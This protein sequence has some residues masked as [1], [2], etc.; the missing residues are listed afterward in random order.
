MRGAL[1]VIAVVVMLTGCGSPSV[2]S[3]GRSEVYTWE[4]P[5]DYRYD[6]ESSCGEQALIG[7]FH[8]TVEDS[9]VVDAKGLNEASEGLL[10]SQFADV[11]PTIEELLAMAHQAERDDAEMLNIEYDSDGVPSL[12]EFDYSLNASDDESCFVITNFKPAN[13]S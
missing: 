3:V 4:S 5:G 6:L 2:D 8:I 7:E 10:K 13:G 11:I 12:I 1:A 9:E